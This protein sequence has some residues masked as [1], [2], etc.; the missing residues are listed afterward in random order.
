MDSLFDKLDSQV[1]ATLLTL[2]PAADKALGPNDAQHRAQEFANQVDLVN[3]QLSELKTKMDEIPH[4]DN[5]TLAIKREI[6]ELRK[7]I[8]LK[9]EVLQKHRN[10]LS[11]CAERLQR[12]DTENRATIEGEH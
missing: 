3:K 11:E 12:V 5:S 1:E 7:D 9:D 4:T 2:F 10:T 6:N 8:R